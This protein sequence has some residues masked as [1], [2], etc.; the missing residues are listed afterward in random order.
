M[1]RERQGFCLRYATTAAARTLMSGAGVAC[2]TGATAGDFALRTMPSTAFVHTGA[3][4]YA[5]A[6]PAS[7]A[8]ASR[9]H[10][11]VPAPVTVI[12]NKLLRADMHNFPSYM[13]TARVTTRASFPEDNVILGRIV[14][15]LW[16]MCLTRVESSMPDSVAPHLSPVPF[17]DRAMCIRRVPHVREGGGAPRRPASQA[18]AIATPRVH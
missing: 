5:S 9:S 14:S 17:G 12:A 2:A 15:S 3:M 18:R 6:T 16:F 8:G 4:A 7:N 13:R 10:V 11:A 1:T